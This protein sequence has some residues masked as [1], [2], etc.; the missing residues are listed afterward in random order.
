MLESCFRPGSRSG[1]PGERSPRYRSCGEPAGPVSHEWNP[2]GGSDT[3]YVL[4]YGWDAHA[5]LH[6]YRRHGHIAIAA[7]GGA[8][9]GFAAGSERVRTAP[10]AADERLRRAPGRPRPSAARS[11]V[12]CRLQAAG[13]GGHHHERRCTSTDRGGRALHT[14]RRASPERVA[15]EARLGFAM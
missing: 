6:T 11:R 13:K 1:T 2:Q 14:A 3:T 5:R 7:R 4:V 9:R 12:R 8:G 10:G 15:M